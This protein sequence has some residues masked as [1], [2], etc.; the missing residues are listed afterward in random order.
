MNNRKSLTIGIISFC[1]ALII[2][3]YC[4]QLPRD[5]QPEPSWNCFSLSHI[6]IGLSL[7]FL[8]T[9]LVYSRQI[10]KTEILI[11]NFGELVLTLFVLTLWEL[12]EFVNDPVIWRIN[13]CNNIWDIIFG[14]VGAFL[15]ICILVIFNQE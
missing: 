4:Q 6:F 7:F 11:L 15:G 3:V 9:F 2:W 13:I 14:L 5:I 8:L 10:F 12:C 1:L